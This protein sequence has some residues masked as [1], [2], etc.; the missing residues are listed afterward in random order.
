M[1]C[2]LKVVQFNILSTRLFIPFSWWTMLTK[3]QE[4][5]WCWNVCNCNRNWRLI[6]SDNISLFLT[7]NFARFSK[8]K[9]LMSF[10]HKSLMMNGE[11]FICFYI[12]DRNNKRFLILSRF[13]FLISPKWLYSEDRK[14]LC[15]VGN[16]RIKISI[17]MLSLA[18]F[19]FHRCIMSPKSANNS[20][21]V[22]LAN[23]WHDSSIEKHVN[24]IEWT[25][26]GICC[27]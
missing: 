23:C 15:F 16:I 20:A 14:M 17:W 19:F 2:A 18:V 13:W 3:S 1:R 25:E 11:M 12:S 6:R 7:P 8:K 22:R 26:L 24:W 5:M 10:L 9:S 27:S 4:K 21:A